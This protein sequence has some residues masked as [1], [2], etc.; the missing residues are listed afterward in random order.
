MRTVFIPTDFSD[1]SLVALKYAV[2]IAQTAGA[3]LVLYSAVHLPPPVA[4]LGAI[5]APPPAD[6]LMEDTRKALLGLAKEL[7]GYTTQRIEVV[8]EL[9][10]ASDCIATWMEDHQPWLT[11]MASKGTTGLERVVWGSVTRYVAEHAPSPVLVLPETYAYGPIES[12]LYATDFQAGDESVT[13]YL[14]DWVADPTELKVHFVHVV[15]GAV[16]LEFEESHLAEF[17]S[18]LAQIAPAPQLSFDL[19]PGRRVAE[20]LETEIASGTWDLVVVCPQH[21][22]WLLR[23]FAPSVSSQLVEHLDLP[24]LVHPGIPASNAQ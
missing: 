13:R 9:G 14:M 20:T 17:E 7:A 5:A 21:R 18:H 19:K 8:V 22:S 1:A 15:D 11:V 10:L 2:E 6:A 12:V 23:L 4:D 24:I 3:E 16:P